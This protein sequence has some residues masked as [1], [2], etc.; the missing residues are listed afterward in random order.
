MVSPWHTCQIS[1]GKVLWVF[2]SE[3]GEKCFLCFSTC[4]T[5]WDTL[6]PIYL[7]LEKFGCEALG[8]LRAATSLRKWNDVGSGAD[9]AHCPLAGWP[10]TCSLDLLSLIIIIFLI[11]Y[12]CFSISP[13]MGILVPQSEVHTRDW[14]NGVCI[15]WHRASS[16][17][18]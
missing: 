17:T 8:V 6:G 12:I 15:V 18:G 5:S 3:S 9:S 2:L 4:V 1:G 10:W 14:R 13:E 16:R 7:V 11:I